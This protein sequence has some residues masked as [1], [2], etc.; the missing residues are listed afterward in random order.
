MATIVSHPA[1][2]GIGTAVGW[3]TPYR[4]PVG[5]CADLDEAWSWTREHLVDR[6]VDGVPSVAPRDLREERRSG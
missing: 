2:R 3:V 5:W 4:F 6:G 1:I